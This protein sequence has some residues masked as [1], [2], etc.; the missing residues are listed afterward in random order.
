VGERDPAEVG[1]CAAG[2]VA[3][4]GGVEDRAVDA[5]A[6]VAPGGERDHAAVAA[7]VPAGH[8]ALQRELRGHPPLG[9]PARGPASSIGPGPQ[10]LTFR[11][12]IA[13]EVGGQQL[14]DVAAV[15]GRAVVGGQP[16]AGERARDGRVRGVAEAEQQRRL[17]PA[18]GQRPRQGHDRRQPDPARDQ[19]LPPPRPA[20]HPPT[21][22]IRISPTPWG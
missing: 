6:S 22:E 2:T 5:D 13:V 8:A 10:A 12:R 21:T 19:H 7:R 14:G 20:G 18:V 1:Q 17:H 15:A 4:A 9:G 3:R 11:A 16:R